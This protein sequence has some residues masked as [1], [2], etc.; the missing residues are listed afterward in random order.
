MIPPCCYFFETPLESLWGVTAP[1]VTLVLK[2]APDQE[3]QQRPLDAWR[4]C[5]KSRE[6]VHINSSLKLYDTLHYYCQNYIQWLRGWPPSSV[7]LAGFSN[8]LTLARHV[9]SCIAGSMRTSGK[10]ARILKR[11]FCPAKYCCK[12]D[13]AKSLKKRIFV[14][15][16]WGGASLML[17]FTFIVVDR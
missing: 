17:L 10:R 6:K 1:K 14:V 11:I 12:K 16:A 3:A 8:I 7:G 5:A 2:K 4:M 13:S 9:P 15:H